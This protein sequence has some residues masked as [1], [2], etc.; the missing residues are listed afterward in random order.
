MSKNVIISY[1][2]LHKK[3]DELFLNR[4]DLNIFPNINHNTIVLIYNNLIDILFE[5]WLN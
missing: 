3:M 4:G 1:K 5:L 2:M